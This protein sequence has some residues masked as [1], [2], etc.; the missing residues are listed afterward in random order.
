[1]DNLIFSSLEDR[2]KW[3]KMNPALSTLNT[4][5]H[6]ELKIYN[7]NVGTGREP[8]VPFKPID[9]PTLD[10]MVRPLEAQGR[11]MADGDYRQWE[12][13][14]RLFHDLSG[15]R[16]VDEEIIEDYIF[17]ADQALYNIIKTSYGRWFAPGAGLKE[18]PI[19]FPDL[20]KYFI[21]FINDFPHLKRRIPMKID[22][23]FYHD[24]D[25]ERRLS[26][27]PHESVRPLRKELNKLKGE[28]V[29]RFLK[30]N[31]KEEDIKEALV[32]MFFDLLDWSHENERAILVR[33]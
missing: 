21:P 7:W 33:Y 24:Y 20:E 31:W 18:I 17:F 25:P 30:T 22:L 15:M 3:H 13:F 23:E 14:K 10:E 9:P 16:K 26:Y 28:M 29:E 11:I 2:R 27:I 1:M 12:F 8:N 19:F 4:T 6:A 5:H 32:P